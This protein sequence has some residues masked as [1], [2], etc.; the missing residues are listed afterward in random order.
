MKIE[1]R[2]QGQ[3]NEVQVRRFLQGNNMDGLSGS[4][5]FLFMPYVCMLVICKAKGLRCNE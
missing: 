5:S 3:I 2:K 1:R 4:K